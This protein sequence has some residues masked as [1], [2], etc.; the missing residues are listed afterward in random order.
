MLSNCEQLFENDVKTY[1]TETQT[2]RATAESWF[3]NDVKT[4]GTE[5]NL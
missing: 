5:T 3:E 1:G 4:Y 2:S